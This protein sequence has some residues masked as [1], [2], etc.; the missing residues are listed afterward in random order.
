LTGKVERG[1]NKRERGDVPKL[2]FL[3]RSDSGT[4]YVL[5]RVVDGSGGDGKFELVGEL[6]TLLGLQTE[7]NGENRKANEKSVVYSWT[8]QN[9]LVEIHRLRIVPININEVWS[10][11]TH[12]VTM[13]RELAP[14]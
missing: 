1:R 3:G 8:Y 4:R 13:H 14:D 7:R 9:Q 2:F 6:A 12:L 11:I 5:T 10:M